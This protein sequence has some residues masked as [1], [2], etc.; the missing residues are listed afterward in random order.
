MNPDATTIG[1]LILALGQL[2]SIA[3]TMKSLFGAQ[4]REISPNPL[5]VRPAAQYVTANDLREHAKSNDQRAASLEETLKRV[6]AR[7]DSL[8]RSDEARTSGL[9]H[10]L[11]VMS[12]NI[13]TL[14]GRIAGM[15]GQPVAMVHEG[16][17]S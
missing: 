10:R 8:D 9:H 12:T 5:E 15:A 16:D 11:N 6:I 14:A 3:L 4:R 13:A 7:M 2:A 17:P 1:I